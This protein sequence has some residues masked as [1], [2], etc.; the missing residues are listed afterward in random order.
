MSKESL[1]HYDPLFIPTPNPKDPFSI[2]YGYLNRDYNSIDDRSVGTQVKVN[3]RWY[4][5]KS[6]DNYYL[7]I[8][9]DVDL[10]EKSLKKIEEKLA[11]L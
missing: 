10:A 5:K 7:F 8:K 2:P 1:C 3:K 9:I 6:D 11:K 4:E